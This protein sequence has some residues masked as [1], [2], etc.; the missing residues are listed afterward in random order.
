MAYVKGQGVTFSHSVDSGTTWTELGKA[1]LTGDVKKVLST[2]EVTGLADSKERIIAGIG[3][4]DDI[5][6]EL[7]YDFTSAT[8]VN[9]DGQIESAPSTMAQWKITLGDS[10]LTWSGILKEY[11]VKGAEKDNV[12][13][14]EFVVA[15]DNGLTIA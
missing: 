12:I 2:I 3:S 1:K 7:F 15:V 11:T 8:H 5:S 9:L 10:S 4:V 6:G 13:M 14:A